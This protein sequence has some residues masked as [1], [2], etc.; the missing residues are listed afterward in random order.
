MKRA[1]RLV[2]WSAGILFVLLRC[3]SAL[4]GVT[5]ATEALGRLSDDPDHVFVVIV[6]VKQGQEA[7]VIKSLGIRRSETVP[8]FGL[9]F[10]KVT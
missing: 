3:G 9:I 2:L 5:L 6:G 7:S 8:E 4:A 1:T 10:V